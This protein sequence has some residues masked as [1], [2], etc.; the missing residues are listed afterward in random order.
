MRPPRQR[1]GD[2]DIEGYV[3][4]VGAQYFGVR[5]DPILKKIPDSD[6]EPKAKGKSP[7]AVKSAPAGESNQPPA[8][9]IGCDGEEE[10]GGLGVTA[11][12]GLN[13]G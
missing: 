12:L 6:S 13:L 5:F 7:K 2:G 11:D 3:E 8:K 10:K 9:G 4:C 1:E